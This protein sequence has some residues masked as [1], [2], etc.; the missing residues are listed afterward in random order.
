MI[1]EKTQCGGGEEEYNYV[2]RAYCECHRL[3]TV[4]LYMLILLLI[5][6]EL[7]PAGMER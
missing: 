2:G 4:L 7:M 3:V 1:L 6:F 5:T